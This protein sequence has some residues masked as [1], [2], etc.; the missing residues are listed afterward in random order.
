MDYKERIISDLSIDEEANPYLVSI[1][2]EVFEF[3]S[4]HDPD[5]HSLLSA[6]SFQQ[7]IPESEQFPSALI[8]ALSYFCVE[9]VPLLEMK[10]KYY[11]EAENRYVDVGPDE[12]SY[13]LE[14]SILVDPSSG[15]EVGNFQESVAVFYS[16]KSLAKD[17]YEQ[18]AS[19]Q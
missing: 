8:K 16:P 6:S 14:T 7:K 18:H 9:R 19:A 10:F 5:H 12:L 1:A 17:I 15:A 13:G 3:F 2:L 4:Q 11:S